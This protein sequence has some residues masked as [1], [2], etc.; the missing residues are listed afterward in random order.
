MQPTDPTLNLYH[1]IKLAEHVL[2]LP[3]GEAPSA[4]IV[5]RLAALVLELDGWLLRGGSLPQQWRA[6]SPTEDA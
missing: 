1:Q 5:T 2:S 6:A 4:D 3:E